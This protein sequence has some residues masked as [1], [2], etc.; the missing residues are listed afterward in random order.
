MNK[1]QTLRSLLAKKQL[2]HMP[3]VYDPL[4]ARLLERAGFESAYVGGW[5][6][7]ASRVITEPLLTMSEQIGVAKEAADAIKIP[8]ICDAGA[9][10]G[11]PLH[12]MRTVRSFIRAGI[13]GV[14]IEDQVY[15]KRAHY[16]AYM[17]DEI[18]TEEF[19]TKIQYAC[20]AR[21][22][23]DPDFVI[24]ARSDTARARGIQEAIDRVNRAADE[25]GADLGMLFPRNADDAEKAARQ[26]RLPL[27]YVISH[28]TRDGR[29]I[30][31]RQELEQMGYAI[32]L[33]PHICMLTAFEAVQ[34]MLTDLRSSGSFTALTE[35][36]CI[37]VRKQIEDMIDLEEFYEIEKATVMKG[38]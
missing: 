24:I 25:T 9:G 18:P 5:I 12:T 19:I 28:G 26:C 30:F 29:P 21:D 2:L 17:V 11:E 4:F 13:S 37:R 32:A 8:L 23:L 22:E 3:A 7:G 14:H 34:N 36:A 33:D 6:T 27:V 16:H 15:P 31:T 20:M 10:F 35:E 1:N 38:A